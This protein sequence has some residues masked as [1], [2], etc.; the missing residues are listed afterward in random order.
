MEKSPDILRVIA[1][2]PSTSH[3]GVCLIDVNIKEDKPF[4]LVYVN[5]IHGDRV[6][7]NVPYAFDD[8]G[9][10]QSRIY[11]LVRAYKQI[12]DIFQPD[13][14]ICEDNYLGVDASAYKRLIEVVSQ[15]KLAALEQA[16]LSLHFVL[17][18]LAKAIVGANFKGTKKEDV[19]K[20]ILNY[21]DLNVGDVDINSL[22]DHSTDAIAIGLF[23]AEL[24]AKEYRPH[25]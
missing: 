14:A 21:P 17:P 10:V 5:T 2:D 15:L 3:M 19:T 6:N 16:N 8:N 12:I 4:D 24:I 9:K 7:F 22:D 23:M 20:G 1:T 11:G 13:F 25:K 18:N